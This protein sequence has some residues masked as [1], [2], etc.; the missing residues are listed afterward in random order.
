MTNFSDV[1]VIL[2]EQLFSVLFP[3]LPAAPSV[4]AVNCN[5]IPKTATQNFDRLTTP[6]KRLR[7][8]R[9]GYTEYYSGTLRVTYKSKLTLSF[10]ASCGGGYEGGGVSV[11]VRYLSMCCKMKYYS[12]SLENEKK[13]IP[14]LLHYWLS[15]YIFSLFQANNN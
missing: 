7:G 3:T 15:Y 5:T 14:Q 13:V 6:S 9:V 10:K 11:N 2:L 12:F 4:P 8:H 1:T